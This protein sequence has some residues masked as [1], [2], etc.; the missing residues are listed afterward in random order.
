MGI[1]CDTAIRNAVESGDIVISPFDE[2]QLN[3][4]SYDIRLGD[5]LYCYQNQVLD[6]AESNEIERI[7]MF[8][9]KVLHPGMLYLAESIEKVGSQKYVPWLDGKSSIGRLG[10]Q[11]H[12]TAG[13]GDVGFCD[14]WTLEISVVQPVRVY[15]G[16]RIGQ[17]TFF[18]IVGEPGQMYQGRYGQTGKA[19]PSKL[20]LGENYRNNG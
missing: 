11:I 16:M 10:I 2:K 13:K 20:Y 15:P 5:N 14:V 9:S 7:S 3:P 12:L 18:N 19:E 17:F 4:N 1:L 8:P 6:A